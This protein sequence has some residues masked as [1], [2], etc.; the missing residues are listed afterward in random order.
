M[1]SFDHARES[2]NGGLRVTAQQAR[3]AF[4]AALLEQRGEFIQLKHFKERMA[5]RGFELTDVVL[6]ARNGRILNPPEFDVKHRE[7]KWRIEGKAIDGRAV[8]VVFSVLGDKRVK[9]ITIET[10]GR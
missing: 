6:L 4:R 7:E 2:A 10:P 5:E 1:L 3:N 8:Y 9:G